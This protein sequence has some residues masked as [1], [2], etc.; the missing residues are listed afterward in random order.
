[1]TLEQDVPSA[2]AKDNITR[3]SNLLIEGA[4]LDETFRLERFGIGIDFFV[5]SHAPINA[6]R[7]NAYL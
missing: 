1:M 3:I 6:T 2:K 5:T 4:V 7:V